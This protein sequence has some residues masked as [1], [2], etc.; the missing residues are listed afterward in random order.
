[1]FWKKQKSIITFNNRRQKLI[2]LLPPTT[3]IKNAPTWWKIKS[4]FKPHITS[5]PGIIELYKKS[6]TIP[7]WVDYE[8]EYNNEFM[9]IKVPGAGA[10]NIHEY[11]TGHDPNQYNNAFSDYYHIKL[12]NPWLIETKELIPFLMIDATW[13]R[14]NFDDYTIPPGILEFKHQHSCHI[15]IFLRK[16]KDT[17]KIKFSAGS[18]FTHLVPL[19]D[20]NFEIKYKKIDIEQFLDLMPLTIAEDNNYYKIRKI[21]E[22]NK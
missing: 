16:S 9:D 12:I 7:L 14:E 6:I 13:N 5:C 2:D 18:K 3:G 4:N 19:E 10:Y 21:A 17:K 20:Y 22:D 11:V 1:M 8:I 15:N